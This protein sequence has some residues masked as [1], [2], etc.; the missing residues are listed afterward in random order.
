LFADTERQFIPTLLRPLSA[1]KQE[2]GVITTP[3][4]DE[5]RIELYS[6]IWTPITGQSAIRVL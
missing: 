3:D 2:Y 4:V 6:E 1:E 5:V